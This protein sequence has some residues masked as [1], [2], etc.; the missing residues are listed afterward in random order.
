MRI[1]GR[2]TL[3]WRV[4]MAAINLKL[5]AVPEEKT[6]NPNPNP[7]DGAKGKRIKDLGNGSQA[8]YFPRFFG[9]EQSWS[10]FNYLD[11]HIRWTRPTIRVFG[12]SCLQVRSPCLLFSDC[13]L[14]FAES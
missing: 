4:K 3:A 12:R 1:E 11:K 14:Q 5:K 6:S 7:N 13:I 9:Y 10:F 8:V 2:G